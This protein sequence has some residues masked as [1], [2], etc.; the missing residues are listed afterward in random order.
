MAARQSLVSTRVIARGRLGGLVAGK[1]ALAVSTASS[2]GVA[3]GRRTV[4]LVAVAA[5]PRPVAPSSGGAGAGVVGGGAALVLVVAGGA[6]LV[7]VVGGGAVFVLA[8]VGGVAL[9]LVVGGGAALVLVVE[10]GGEVFVLVV[11]DD[12]AVLV[13]AVVDVPVEVAG[14]SLRI[15][16]PARKAA[17]T[18]IGISRRWVRVTGRTITTGAG[19]SRRIP[20][21]ALL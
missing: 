10:G 6:A 15:E 1:T 4:S 5:D 2:M 3:P 17:S 21:V 18:R 14:G 19:P 20:P 16:Q 13:V 7:L 8:V 11:G 9:V 12:D